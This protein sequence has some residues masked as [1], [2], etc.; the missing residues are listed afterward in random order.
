MSML[1]VHVQLYKNGKLY[2]VMCFRH[3]Y[4]DSGGPS[5]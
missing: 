4:R 2:N 3:A 1:T 5:A